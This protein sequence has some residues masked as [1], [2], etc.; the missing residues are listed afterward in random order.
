VVGFW[1]NALSGFALLVAD[2][3]TMMVS[4]IFR[5]KMAAIALAWIGV[6]YWGWMLPFLGGAF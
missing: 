4:W 1:I 6:I 5:V 2:A 3:S